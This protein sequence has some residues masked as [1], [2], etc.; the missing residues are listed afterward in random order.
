LILPVTSDATTQTVAW[1]A[2][3]DGLPSLTTDGSDLLALQ[4]S[5]D[6][7]D[8]LA[9]YDAQLTIDDLE[10][11][12][13]EPEPVGTGGEGGAASMPHDGGMGGS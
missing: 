13:D 4:W 1:T 2:F 7:S 11:Y 12:H 8:E 9:P 10:F 3:K 5:F 6:W